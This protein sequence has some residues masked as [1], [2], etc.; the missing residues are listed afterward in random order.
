M[1]SKKVLYT[2]LLI[3]FFLKPESR[4]HNRQHN[5]Q[6]NAECDKDHQPRFEK[7]TNHVHDCVPEIGERV[8]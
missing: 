2:Q 5:L 8:K 1:P 4:N 6:P 7:A 3:D